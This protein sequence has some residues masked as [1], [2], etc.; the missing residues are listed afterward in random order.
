VPH[1]ER[2]TCEAAR[3][4]KEYLV[5]AAQG[6]TPDCS[7]GWH[8]LSE[9]IGIDAKPLFDVP[10]E[11]TAR[12]VYDE[13]LE[14]GWLIIYNGRAAARQVC[15]FIAHELAEYLALCECPNLFHDM[16]QQ[17]AAYSGGTDPDDARHVIA[18]RVEGLCF[19]QEAAY[20]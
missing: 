5:K 20:T 19:A 1:K 3:R 8:L 9:R 18:R 4:I 11:F 14:G 7:E 2:N 12:L 13:R 15:H 10:C 6:P 17:V 16:P